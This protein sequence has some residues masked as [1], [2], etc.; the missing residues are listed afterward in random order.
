MEIETAIKIKLSGVMEQ[1]NQSQTQ[2][3]GVVD[4]D[5][6]DEYFIDTAEMEE[7]FTQFLQRQKN[8]L[9]GLNEHF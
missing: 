8:Q 2:R 9:I 4:F 6:D 5:D 7:L 3:E 1:V